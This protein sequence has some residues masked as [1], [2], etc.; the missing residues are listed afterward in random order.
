MDPAKLER[1][2]QKWNGWWADKQEDHQNHPNK[3]S[4]DYEN[5]RRHMEKLGQ[6]PAP[7]TP[8]AAP[9]MKAP[10]RDDDDDRRERHRGKRKD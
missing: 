2:V 5:Y 7:F 6:T 1:K 3:L 4:K 10:G 8:G 9:S